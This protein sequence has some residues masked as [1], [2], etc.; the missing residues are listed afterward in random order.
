MVI[1]STVSLGGGV[2]LTSLLNVAQQLF[3]H[4]GKSL[5]PS[6]FSPASNEKTAEEVQ[7]QGH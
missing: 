4:R 2:F 3:S 6:S 1:K 5:S 7:K